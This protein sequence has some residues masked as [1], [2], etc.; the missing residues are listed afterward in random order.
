M[1][2]STI[3]LGSGKSPE[4]LEH[5][6]SMPCN[7]RVHRRGVKS[8]EFTFKGHKGD[9]QSFVCWKML[10]NRSCEGQRRMLRIYEK[11]KV[12]LELLTNLEANLSVWILLSLSLGSVGMIFRRDENAEFN[13]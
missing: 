3:S 8:I 10:L 9:R 6:K 5:V 12:M 11:N 13:D 4:A 7:C 2:K 1:E